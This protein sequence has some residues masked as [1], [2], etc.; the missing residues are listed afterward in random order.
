MKR[1][2]LE[3]RERELKR[4]EKKVEVLERKMSVEKPTPGAYIQNL[5]SLFRYDAQEIFNTVDDVDILELLENMKENLPEKQWDNV[6]KKA[7]K[8]TN[9]AQ[10]DR[11]FDEIKTLLN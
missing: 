2:E 10:K 11:A 5:F 3:R 7:I 4:S 1:T 6:L 9:I 8:K